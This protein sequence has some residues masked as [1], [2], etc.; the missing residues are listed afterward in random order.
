MLNL[1]HKLY[2][3]ARLSIV[4]TFEVEF[5]ITPE[6]FY[7]RRRKDKGLDVI[8]FSDPQD[9]R[10]I[11]FYRYSHNDLIKGIDMET[12]IPSLEGRAALEYLKNEY[13]I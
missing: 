9:A 12:D 13:L 4:D 10:T 11:K 1:H 3:T 7:Y 6:I 8:Q 5:F 2:Q